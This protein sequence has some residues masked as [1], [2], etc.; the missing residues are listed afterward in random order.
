MLVTVE[1][2]RKPVVVGYELR[3][4]YNDTNISEHQNLLLRWTQV[5]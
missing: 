5:E 3:P 2:F 4:N 1:A